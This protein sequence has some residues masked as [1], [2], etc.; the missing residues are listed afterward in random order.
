MSPSFSEQIGVESVGHGEFISQT[1]PMRMA[2]ARPVAY[3]GCS[4]S[5]A[6]SAACATTKSSLDLYSV[7][8]HFHGPA[9]P[10]KSF[11]APSKAPETRGHFQLDEF[12]F[13]RNNPTARL[14]LA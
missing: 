6:V 4:L 7:V 8:G 2:N 9:S 5:V 12:G 1:L 11:F 14:V 10:N 13:T 3:G